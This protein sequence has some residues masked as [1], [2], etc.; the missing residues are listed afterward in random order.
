MAGN[1]IDDE[2]GR[3]DFSRLTSEPKSGAEFEQLLLSSKPRD[4]KS[5]FLF[6]FG[7]FF[8]S[9]VTLSDFPTGLSVSDVG[10]FDL[11]AVD[12]VRTNFLGDRRGVMLWKA[13]FELKAKDIKNL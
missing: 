1:L 10:N 4:L 3:T 12:G 2:F 8:F 5:S 9:G 13:S 11:L 6:S 7:L